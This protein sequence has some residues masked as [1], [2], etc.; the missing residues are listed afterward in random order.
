MNAPLATSRFWNPMMRCTVSSRVGVS[1]NFQRVEIA[2]TDLE[3][4]EIERRIEIVAEGPLT[5]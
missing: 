2:K 5:G 4:V 3:D 1:S